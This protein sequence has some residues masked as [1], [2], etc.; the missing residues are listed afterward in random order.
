MTQHF[1]IA[2]IVFEAIEK[3]DT[4]PDHADDF[5]TVLGTMPLTYEQHEALWQAAMAAVCAGRE[6]AFKLGWAMRGQV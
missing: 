6:D 3:A 1:D 2:Q 4:L 5:T